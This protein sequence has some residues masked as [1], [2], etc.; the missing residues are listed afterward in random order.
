M[1]TLYTMPARTRAPVPTLPWVSLAVT[2]MQMWSAAAVVIQQR[3]TRMVLAGPNPNARDRRE[4]QRMGI[5][6]LEAAAE[7]AN[8]MAWHSA[9]SVPQAGMLVMQQ[10]VRVAPNVFEAAL[11]GPAALFALQGAWWQSLMRNYSA[12]GSHHLDT[13]AT[14]A[15]H[16]MHPLHRRVTANARRLSAISSRS[17]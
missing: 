14:V 15:R 1:H 6:K 4:F 5:E 8:A 2:G 12:L 10:W 9:A 3:V 16:G 17:R 13:A 11:Q 7:S